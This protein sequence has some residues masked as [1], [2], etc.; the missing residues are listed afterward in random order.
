VEVIDLGRRGSWRAEQSGGVEI[1]CVGCGYGGV[2][3][4]L[5]DRC[6]MCGG[7]SWQRISSTLLRNDRPQQLP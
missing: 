3:V 5:P 2:V 6:P 4:R 1:R 7:S